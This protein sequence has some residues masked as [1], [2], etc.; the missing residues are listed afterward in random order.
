MYG[1][2][3]AFRKLGDDTHP[4][5]VEIHTAQLLARFEQNQ[6]SGSFG[7]AL[8]ALTL[9]VRHP[10]PHVAAFVAAVNHFMPGMATGRALAELARRGVR[11]PVWAEQLGDVEPGRM[12][13]RLFSGSGRRS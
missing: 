2:A 13:T 1:E 11:P 9:A 3:E 12:C 7:L 6:P 4:L 10:Q 8:G 5:D